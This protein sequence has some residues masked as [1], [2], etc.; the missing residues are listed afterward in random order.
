MDDI[1]MAQEIQLDDEYRR[2]YLDPVNPEMSD[3]DYAE[4]CERD[5][6]RDDC[7]RLYEGR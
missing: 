6:T 5:D 3:D 7:D 2:K 1:D 4:Q